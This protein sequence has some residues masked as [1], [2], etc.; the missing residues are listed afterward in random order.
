MSHPV[1]DAEELAALRALDTPTVCNALEVVCPERR[2]HGYT[3]ETFVA[4]DSGL[5]PIVG[6]AATAMIRSIRPGSLNAAEM[7]QQ[8]FD[9]YRFVYETPGPTVSVVQDLD[10]GRA[11]FGSF[12]GEVNSAIHKALGCAGAITDGSMRDLDDIAPGFQILAHKVV[13]SHAFVH[14]EDFGVAVSVCGMNVRAGDLIH[15]DQH[16]AVV[17]PHE[18]ARGIADA[19]AGVATKEKLVLDAARTEPFDYDEF[20]AAYGEMTK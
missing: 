6:Y 4:V 13:P 12:W 16:G 9:Y 5:P 11:G 2:G 15:A 8:R 1:L 7:R 18:H 19:A 20:V 14:L 3:E 17:I 10:G